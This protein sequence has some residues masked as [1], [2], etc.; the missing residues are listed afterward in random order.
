[1]NHLERNKHNV[2]QFYDLIFNQGKPREGVERYV[3]AQYVQH[4]PHVADG[5]DAFIDFFEHKANE[6]PDKRINFKRVIAEGNYVVVHSQQE[7]PSEHDREWASI[8][9]F[10]LDDNGKIVEHWDVVQPV[11]EQSANSNTMF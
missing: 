1:M 6:Y 11:P 5:K 9:I 8:D 3:G 2:T 7:W 4:N 10:R